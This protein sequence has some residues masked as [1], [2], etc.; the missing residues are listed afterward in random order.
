[1]FEEF[2]D[3]EFQKQY[4]KHYQ[5][6]KRIPVIDD[7]IDGIRHMG[8]ICTDIKWELCHL[9]HKTKNMLSKVAGICYNFVTIYLIIQALVFISLIVLAICGVNVTWYSTISSYLPAPLQITQNGWHAVLEIALWITLLKG[10]STLKNIQEYGGWRSQLLFPIATCYFIYSMFNYNIFIQT[11]TWTLVGCFLMNW[12]IYIGPWS[13]GGVP[14]PTVSSRGGGSS[15]DD[16]DDEVKKQGTTI[17]TQVHS[18]P[19][20][21]DDTRKIQEAYQCGDIVKVNAVRYFNGSPNSYS[22]S[23]RGQL[24][25]FSENMVVI[26]DQGL[27]YVCDATGNRR[28]GRAIR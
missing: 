3:F 1:M 24:M 5:E 25:S 16:E 26:I 21:P 28:S 27:Q 7:I 8:T 10:L 15:K 6:P 4:E 13:G 12:F 2:N 9:K 11:A 17:H 23:T 14:I 18:T 22:W 20:I 19:A